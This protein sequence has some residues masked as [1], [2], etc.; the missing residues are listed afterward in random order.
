MGNIVTKCFKKGSSE[1]VKHE[2]LVIDDT[3]R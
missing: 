1:N 3:T 2:K